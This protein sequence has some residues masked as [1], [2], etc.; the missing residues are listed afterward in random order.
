MS[1]STVGAFSSG[2]TRSTFGSGSYSTGNTISSSGGSF[3]NFTVKLLAGLFSSLLS[4][5]SNTQTTVNGSRTTVV[6]EINPIL[7]ENTPSTSL[8][9]IDQLLSEEQLAQTQSLSVPQEPS[10]QTQ[11][12][13]GNSS[14]L[15][16]F[17]NLTALS[18]L[19]PTLTNTTAQQTTSQNT[20]TQLSTSGLSA[21][22]FVPNSDLSETNLGSVA[23]NDLTNLN[24]EWTYS[25]QHLSDERSLAQAQSDLQWL[26]AQAQAL[27]DSQNAGTCDT[28]CESALASIESQIPDAE[29]QVAQFTATVNEPIPAT[30]A[31][32]E[33]QT[34][35][36]ATGAVTSQQPVF[37][38]SAPSGGSS[39]SQI[40]ASLEQLA[41]QSVTP[42]EQT[43]APQATSVPAG[44]SSDEY[45]AQQ[46]DLG[47]SQIVTPA[48][49]PSPV[50]QV[51]SNVVQT[52]A[53]WFSPAS[54]STVARSQ[55]CSLIVSLFGGCSGW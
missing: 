28:N 32:Q 53:N 39:S 42:A 10:A 55:S 12:Q 45:A 2:A 3:A 47:T 49:P 24:G 23:L 18:S 40:P 29:Q 5:P 35:E 31:A 48:A 41:S 7:I 26:Q 11:T 54:T 33:A 30:F 8:S 21:N 16:L 13:S 9:P 17:T 34:E 14:I 22:T 25:P 50:E 38:Q 27:E 51:I 4:T 6:E 1:G 52:V 44:T 19:F 37:S 15:D 46:A 20:I 43:S 36:N